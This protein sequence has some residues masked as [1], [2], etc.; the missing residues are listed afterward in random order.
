MQTAFVRIINAHKQKTTERSVKTWGNPDEMMG[1]RYKEQDEEDGEV[2]LR[3]KDSSIIQDED[4]DDAVTGDKD[5]T[6]KN[7]IRRRS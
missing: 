2:D 6:D 3:E 7:V 1:T 4:D 5:G